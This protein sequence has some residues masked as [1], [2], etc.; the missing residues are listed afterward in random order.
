MNCKKDNYFTTPYP[1]DTTSTKRRETVRLRV[2]EKIPI[3]MAPQLKC[4]LLLYDKKSKYQVIHSTIPK[5]IT[6]AIQFWSIN[7]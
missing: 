1:N 5:N 7:N 4:P 2:L 3:T 6:P